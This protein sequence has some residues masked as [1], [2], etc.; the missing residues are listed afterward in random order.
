MVNPIKKAVGKGAPNDSGDV[1][2]IQT[3]LFVFFTPPEDGDPSV[4]VTGQYDLKTEEAIFKFQGM[5]LGKP[6]GKIDPNGTTWKRLL[7]AITIDLQ[8]LPNPGTG[9]YHYASGAR[10]WGTMKMIDTLKSACR[11]LNVQKPDALVG[12]GDISFRCGGKMSPHGTHQKGMNVDIRP[13]RKDREQK[14]C[15]YTEDQY[16]R[17]ATQL[18]VT[19]LRDSGNVRSILFNDNKV[20]GVSY[21]DGHDNHLHV[22]IN[23]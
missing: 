20:K 12:I 5:V 6:D 3:L 7:D 23:V 13:L 9:Y 8:P 21:H 14:P 19:L 1:L 16:D 2:I 11:E 17:E 22:T 4:P 10:Q 15:F 18:L